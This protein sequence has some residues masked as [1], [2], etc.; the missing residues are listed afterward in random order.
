M[1]N[2]CAFYARFT[3]RIGSSGQKSVYSY[4]FFPRSIRLIVRLEYVLGLLFDG[5]NKKGR[6]LSGRGV[7]CCLWMTRG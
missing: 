3:A 1:F 6:R 4:Q 5:V 2:R 7:V